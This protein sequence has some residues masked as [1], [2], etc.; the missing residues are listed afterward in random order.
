[1]AEKQ[2][3][4]PVYFSY[5]KADDKCSDIEESVKKICAVLD[6]NGI[7]YKR[8]GDSDIPYCASLD[9]IQRETGRGALVIVIISKG[10]I[11]SLDCMHEWHCIRENGKIWE[12]VLP[13]VME[14][15][16]L[17]DKEVFMDYYNFFVDRQNSLIDQQK[18]GIIPLTKSE[19]NAAEFGY[20]IEDLKSMYKYLADTNY[21]FDDYS[22]LADRIRE[23][24]KSADS[25][26]I[27]NPDFHYAAP[28]HKF[29]G[30]EKLKTEI[31]QKFEEFNVINIH[32]IGGI[33]K[34]S[35]AHLYIEKYY[36]QENF[37]N[38]V[39]HIYS[40]ENV[41]TDFVGR[42]ND[43]LDIDLSDKRDYRVQ[44][45]TVLDKLDT[46][47]GK[48]LLVLDINITDINVLMLFPQ[49]I[50]EFV[51]RLRNW[52]VLIL[53]RTSIVAESTE[54]IYLE[55]FGAIEEDRE[56]ISEIFKYNLRGY[57]CPCTEEELQKLFNKL[58]YH[59]L[60]VEHLA[61]FV[62]R[63]KMKSF[64]E[65]CSAINDFSDNEVTDRTYY[66][67]GISEIGKAEKYQKVLNFLERII[68]YDQFEDTEQ[69]VL[70]HFILW[71]YDDIPYEVIQKLLKGYGIKYL[72]NTLDDLI[73]K[74]VLQEKNGSYRM[75]GSLAEVLKKQVFDGKRE[76]DYWQ[77]FENI[78]ELGYIKGYSERTQCIY[79]TLEND[80]F[81]NEYYWNKL[82]KKEI[83]DEELESEYNMVKVEGGDLYICKYVVTQGDWLKFYG[84]NPSEYQFG[85]NYPVSKV[86]WYDALLYVM[87]LN[88]VTGLCFRLP[89]EREWKLA[90][91]YSNAPN[92]YV[93]YIAWNIVNSRQCTHDAKE[94][95]IDFGDDHGIKNMLGN[96]LEWCS[97]RYDI[98][99]PYRVACGGSY[100]HDEGA[101]RLSIR[102][103]GFPNGRDNRFGFRLALSAS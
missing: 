1:M 79:A 63:R 5:Y 52:H 71:P 97:D 47:T 16:K 6:T 92:H 34:T 8:N 42:V 51:T 83:Y 13:V 99:S 50:D 88:T 43:Y 49:Y 78:I 12:R 30:R 57:P 18:K 17:R 70:R 73:D 55:D 75:H 69:T 64:D 32:G 90:C 40:N 33:G 45:Q 36:T 10:Y 66:G 102:F 44:L 65:I 37:Y 103:Y 7:C 4:N 23:V 98:D 100:L 87:K 11:E 95:P 101:C 74:T 25:A 46:I 77:Y 3:I 21:R 93:N 9:E 38:K 76:L 24:L 27:F 85:S 48:N 35:F 22:V 62:S 56:A 60:L 80:D 82:P 84:E 29:F 68:I 20:Y 59:P 81:M 26:A 72:R 28:S 94:Q 58:M 15:A 89:T 19:T 96:V 54:R 14:D 67:T 41:V 53:S 39:C 31:R 61:A 91:D 2:Y 86:S